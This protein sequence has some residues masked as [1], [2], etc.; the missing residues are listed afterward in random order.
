MNK[1]TLAAVVALIATLGI[2]VAR[3]EDKPATPVAPNTP[4][5]P[6]E[7]PFKAFFEQ[8]KAETKAYFEAQKKDHEAFK[9]TLKDKTPEERKPLIEAYRTTQQAKTKAFMTKQH[10]EAIAKINGSDL[11]AE[12]KAEMIT[13][14]QERWTEQQKKHA[15]R[16]AEHKTKME[17]KHA[18]HKAAKDGEKK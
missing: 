1:I 11:P 2:T 18:E 4:T 17:T 9:A 8:Q 14:L 5:A 15:E 3:A 12:K 10:D 6:K 13:H 16:A 7:R